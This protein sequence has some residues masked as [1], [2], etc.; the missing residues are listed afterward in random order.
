MSLTL[1]T[2]TLLLNAIAILRSFP[3]EAVPDGHIGAPHHLYIGVGLA[4]LFVGSAW[5]DQDRDP[6]WTA[7]TLLIAVFAFGMIWPF[8][9]IVGAVGVLMALCGTVLAVWLDR[10][11]W[12]AHPRLLAGM[13]LGWLIALDDAVEHAFGVP[14]PLDWLFAEWIYP[15]IT[16]IVV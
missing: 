2:Y 6:L 16:A 7:L 11:V 4:L 5:D 10:A 8:Y 15:Y 14:T 1:V 12:Q 3:H 9:P 13:A